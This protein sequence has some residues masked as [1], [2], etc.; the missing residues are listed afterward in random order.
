MNNKLLLIFL[1]VLPA[2]LIVITD[3]GGR[4]SFVAHADD[5]VEDEV[6]GEDDVTIDDEGPGAGTL[7]TDAVVADS[8]EEEEEEEEKALQASPDAQTKIVF[9]KP[10]NYMEMPAGAIVKFLVGFINNGEK[11]FIVDSID[12][13]FRYPQD[14]SFYIQNFTAAYYG[15]LV[16]SKKQATFDYS[17]MP[18]ENFNAR[19]F[20]LTINL[21][22]R[23]VEGSLY[24][25]ALFNE[26]ISIIE[27]DEGLDGETFF[28][29]V[30][31]AAV[32][33]LL[34]VAGQQFLASFTK[35]RGQRTKAPVEMGTSNHNDVDYDWIPKQTLDD[36]KKSPRRTP[37][38]SP[39][40]RRT[41]GSSE[42]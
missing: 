10:D 28:L 31:L 14:Y 22:Y 12:A 35:K 8:E 25:D 5:A 16:E 37:R 18:S 15:R 20:G 26:T 24:Q 9:S 23:D 41:K 36:M 17:F 33:V 7:E 4:S 38:Q 29:Y 1:L 32:A 3:G 42:D 13:A 21:N 2:V 40:Q 19:P 30:F 34:L 39:R 11:D 27:V 6:E